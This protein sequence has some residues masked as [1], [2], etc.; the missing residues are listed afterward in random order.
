MF[1][2]RLSNLSRAALWSIGLLSLSIGAA[3]AA[4]V[5]PDSADMNRVPSIDRAADMT[6]K[7]HLNVAIAALRGQHM[8]LA[9]DHLE[10]A[11]TALLNR[12]GIDLGTALKADQALP[13]TGPIDYIVNARAS[14][15]Q[16]D[17]PNAVREVRHALTAIDSERA[18]AASS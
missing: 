4:T 14:L 12:E 9:R 18:M 2:S 6:A 15:N 16:H 5:A 3:N 1:V 13:A 8:K 11:E 7:S 17:V 10:R